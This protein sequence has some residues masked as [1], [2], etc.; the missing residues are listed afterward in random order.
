MAVVTV[1]DKLRANGLAEDLTADKML[2]IDDSGNVGHAPKTVVTTLGL[3]PVLLQSNKTDENN[4]ESNNG[5]AVLEIK[6]SYSKIAYTDTYMSFDGTDAHLESPESVTVVSPNVNVTGQINVD[7]TG[8]DRTAIIN[9]EVAL[10][11]D[12]DGKFTG[13]SADGIDINNADTDYRFTFTDGSLLNFKSNDHQ[14]VILAT[15]GDGTESYGVLFPIK[16]DAGIETL[17]MVSDIEVI[18]FPQVL[19]V[20]NK[21]GENSIT[22]NDSMSKL[23]LL[24]GLVNLSYASDDMILIDATRFNIVATKTIKFDAPDV[25]FLTKSML[26][27]NVVESGDF[28]LAFDAFNIFVTFTG[29]S[30]SV[31]S[32]DTIAGNTGVSVIFTNKGLG[33]LT[34]DVNGSDLIWESGTTM[35]SYPV[36][37][38]GT[39]KLYNDGINLNIN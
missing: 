26:P 36:A 3:G 32:L 21:T 37:P 6:D 18:G 11:Q 35:G 38:G 25:A 4:I 12:I 8:S 28:S 7:A 17:A 13:V 29:S 15:Q 24:D 31:C 39:L 23:D 14:Q 10:F 30:P 34:I 33:I 5:N 19:S 27:K 2:V 22:S 1:V 16:P 9:N 20:D